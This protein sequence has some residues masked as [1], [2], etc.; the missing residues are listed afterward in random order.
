MIIKNIHIDGFGIYHDFS[1]PTHLEKGINILYGE[2]EA[3][4]STLLQFLR[5]TLFGYPS[6]RKSP[7]MEPLAGGKHGGRIVAETLSG[8]QVIFERH[9]ATKQGQIQLHYNHKVYN[10]ENMWFRLLGN[11]NEK[12]FNNIYAFTLDELI[13]YGSLNDSGMQDRLFSIGMGLNT[14]SIQE[15]ENNI[16]N[17]MDQI[18]VERGRTKKV[19]ELLEQIKTKQS[20][21]TKLKDNKPLFNEISKDV[22]ILEGQSEILETKIND[23]HLNLS[24]TTNLLKCYPHFVALQQIDNN[25]LIL[26]AYEELPGQWKEDLTTAE[27]RLRRYRENKNKLTV[28]TNHSRGKHESINP[29]FQ[30]LESKPKITEMRDNLKLYQ[31]QIRNYQDLQARHKLIG[32]ETEKLTKQLG[33]NV[34][35]SEIYETNSEAIRA[36]ITAFINQ[37]KVIEDRD[38]AS[39]VKLD[40]AYDKISFLNIKWISITAGL[41]LLLGAAALY[42]YNFQPGAA[43]MASAGVIMI[44]TGPFMK[45][46]KKLNILQQQVVQT[47]DELQKLDVQ[48]SSYIKNTFKTNLDFEPLT[49]L[50]MT[51]AIDQIQEKVRQKQALINQMEGLKKNIAS[52]EQ[53]VD[54]LITKIDKKIPDNVKEVVVHTLLDL[55]QQE[56]NHRQKKE[57]LQNEINEQIIDLKTLDGQIS[58]TEEEI[59]NILANGNVK[60]R[61]EFIKRYEQNKNV[62]SLLDEKKANTMA[63]EIIFGPGKSNAVAIELKATDKLKLETQSFNLDTSLQDLKNEQKELLDRLGGIKKERDNLMN[64]SE[65]ARLATEIETLKENL[66]MARQDWLTNRIALDLLHS[67]K[68]KYEKEKQP[69][70]IGKAKKHFSKITGGKYPDLRVPFGQQG[71][72][73]TDRHEKRKALHTLSRGTKEQLLLSLR[74][75]FIESYEKEAEPLPVVMDEVLVNFDEKRAQKISEI[76][77]DFGQN[78]QILIFTCHRHT[79]DLFD[80][81]K[82]N[83]LRL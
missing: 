9:A 82:I 10:D 18:Y 71:V 68:N 16:K 77:N 83:I 46:D 61:D 40:A 74:L 49:A 62:A 81:N 78:R 24:K 7:K 32:D 11:A 73:I 57:D 22:V 65:L 44:L 36:K 76:L 60:T 21:L 66:K 58:T 67:V 45:S 55:L 51:G 17:S 64:T 12:L 3:G 33:T 1:L 34:S 79:A 23:T 31:E 4:K 53:N 56:E 48:I 13:D 26:P 25:L 6:A 19:N 75:G 59:I 30:I 39:R 29:D 14:A 47:E 20:H 28:K 42:Y 70:V 72:T 52:Y 15:I 63:I 35:V 8:D 37:H 41:I 80:N 43:L 69:E 5:Y 54:Q 50:K 38:S 27:E 2:N